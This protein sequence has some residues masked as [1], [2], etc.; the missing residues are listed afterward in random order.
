MSR[1]AAITAAAIAVA[2][3]ASAGSSAE[4]QE[5]GTEVGGTV[6]ST[7]ELSIDAVGAFSP[8]AAGPTS[9]QLLVRAR[10]TSTDEAA[11]LSIADGD[12]AAGPRLGRLSAALSQP[13]EVRLGATGPFTPLDEAADIELTAFTGP[14]ANAAAAL[15]IR[16]RVL[17][18]ERPKPS[19]PKTLLITLSS[20]AP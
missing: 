11:T 7:L 5:P 20:D 6:P 16:Q 1:R 17:A 19:Y 14:V 12:A 9:R 15:R 18:G 2:V 13:L 8:F 10:V 3:A 4:G